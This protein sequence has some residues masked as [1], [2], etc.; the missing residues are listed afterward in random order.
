MAN[1]FVSLFHI[2]RRLISV[3]PFTCSLIIVFFL[4]TMHVF[5]CRFLC[6]SYLHC[7]VS[8]FFPFSHSKVFNIGWFVEPWSGWLMFLFLMLLAD[9]YF[10]ILFCHVIFVFFLVIL[11][12]VVLVFFLFPLHC[13]IFVL[14][15]SI[16]SYLFFFLLTLH[17]V[18][19]VFFLF[20]LHGVVFVFHWLRCMVS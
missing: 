5:F 7:N 13:I 18:V 12:S 9:W 11:H 19:F 4:F 14:F 15:F 2:C 1:I 16:A 8:Y 6:S 10:V 20:T 17:G 3:F